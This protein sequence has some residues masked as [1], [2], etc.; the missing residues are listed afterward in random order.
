AAV[1]VEDAAGR[2]AV[3]RGAMYLSDLWA[4]PSAVVQHSERDS[5]MR[6]LCE[7]MAAMLPHR[8]DENRHPLEHG[9]D[10]EEAVDTSAAE[11]ARLRPIPEAIPRLASLDCLSVFDAALHDAFGRLQ[12]VSTFATL[13][14]DFLPGDLSRYLGA[15]GAGRHLSEFLRPAPRRL[16]DAWLI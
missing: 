15:A 7:A 11:V 3:G 16:L 5:A 12:G 14:R 10:W 13:T 8:G 1:T 6:A 2:R 9:V 4:W